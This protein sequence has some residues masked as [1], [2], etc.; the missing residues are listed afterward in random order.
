[1]CCRGMRQER[2][3]RHDGGAG[4]GLNSAARIREWRVIWGVRNT[5]GMHDILSA[6]GQNEQSASEYVE[7]KKEGDH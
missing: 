1:M 2:E 6:S 4:G 3:D 7:Q 5:E